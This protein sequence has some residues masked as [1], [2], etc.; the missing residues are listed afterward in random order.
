MFSESINQWTW[1]VVQ[2]ERGH[3]TSFCMFAERYWDPN[4]I[5]KRQMQPVCCNKW[6]LWQLQTQQVKPSCWPVRAQVP[7]RDKDN[8]KT[9]KNMKNSSRFKCT[10]HDISW[11]CMVKAYLRL[12]HVSTE[13]L[14]SLYCNVLVAKWLELKG[15]AGCCPLAAWRPASARLASAYADIELSPKGD[16]AAVQAWNLWQPTASQYKWRK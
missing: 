11:R 16:S 6:Q 10:L 5:G 13:S 14:Q 2:Y 15:P 4:L 12:F 8:W 1:N 7:G 9:W 3:S